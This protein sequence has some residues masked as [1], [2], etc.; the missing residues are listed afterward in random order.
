MYIQRSTVDELSTQ[1]GVAFR[2]ENVEYHNKFC[3]ENAR[4]VLNKILLE[5]C[6][7]AT[8]LESMVETGTTLSPGLATRCHY[9]YGY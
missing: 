6:K 2:Q 3:L 8:T 5:V 4:K 7:W 1:E 9:C